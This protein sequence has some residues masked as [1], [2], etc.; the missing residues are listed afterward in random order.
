MKTF[1][2]FPVQVIKIRLI[3]LNLWLRIKRAK[4][5]ISVL[6]NSYRNGDIC[7]GERDSLIQEALN[8]IDKASEKADKI[9]RELMYLRSI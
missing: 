5:E 9:D 7:I 6:N 8:I 1:F 3:Q 2:R 4:R